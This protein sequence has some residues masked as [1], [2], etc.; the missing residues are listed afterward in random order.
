MR[1]GLVFVLIGA[2]SASA[3][4][5]SSSSPAGAATDGAV[6]SFV[7]SA[8][9]SSVDGASDVATEAAAKTCTFNR[10]CPVAQ[11]CACTD[12]DGCA[13][14]VGPRGTGK[15]GIDTCTTGND[16][17]SSLCVEGPG[18]VYTCSGEC[19]GAG[20][21]KGSLPKCVDVAGLGKICARA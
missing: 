2:S 16:C 21:C 13:C 12:A 14:E 18:S 15:S 8:R 19:T 10:D 5:S 3:G 7:D 6:D 9:E 17:E 11:R 1:F 20:D 4:C